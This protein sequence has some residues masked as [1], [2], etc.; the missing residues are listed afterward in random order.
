M[1]LGKNSSLLVVDEPEVYLHADLQRQLVGLLRGMGPDI[2]IATHSTEIMTEADPS[3]IL[4]VNKKK[5]KSERLMTVE[6]L[7]DALIQVGSIQNITLA[8]LSRSRRVLFVEDEYDFKILRWFAGQLGYEQLASGLD[9]T[10]VKSDGFSSW[11]KISAL[12][13]GL[14]KV[15]DEVLRIGV[16]YDRD[17]FCKE[18]IQEVTEALQKTAELVHVHSRKEIENYLLNEA[19]LTRAVQSSLNE[20]ASREGNL[21]VEIISS[22]SPLLVEI[23]ESYKDDSQSQYIGKKVDYLRHTPINSATLTRQTLLEFSQKWEK[24]D[25]RLELV[26]GKKVLADFRQ[27]I[28]ALYGVTITDLRIISAFKKEE[29]PDDLKNLVFGLDEFRKS[30]N[31]ETDSSLG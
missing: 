17:Y 31:L 13:W 20:K 3:E 8:R 9:L 21:P 23:A 28:S 7:Q 2:I 4:L 30:N 5:N 24:L 6:K 22:V 19:V 29:I 15:L 10:P 27:K 12:G 11:R 25:T 1:M 14:E 18:E 16:I 26:P